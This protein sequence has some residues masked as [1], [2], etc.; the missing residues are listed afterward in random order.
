M[1]LVAWEMKKLMKNPVWMGLMLLFLAIDVGMVVGSPDWLLQGERPAFTPSELQADAV[2]LTNEYEELDTASYGDNAVRIMNGGGRE[3]EL[4]SALMR[5]KYAQLTP[6]VEQMART[7][8]GLEVTVSE[9]HY[10]LHHL[11]YGTLLKTVL[12]QAMLLAALLSAQSIDFETSAHT[13]GMVYATRRGR[14]LIVDKCG[15]SA[16]VALVGYL[17]L[18]AAV[19]VAFACVYPV[20]PV[21]GSSVSSLLHRVDF[22]VYGWQPFMTW[23]RFSEITYLPAVVLVGAGLVLICVFLAICL[24]TFLPNSYVAL[25][26]F[27]LL[28][29]LPMLVS[30]WGRGFAVQLASLTPVMVWQMIRHWFTDGY[31]LAFIPWFE[32]I[33]TLFYLMLSGAAAAFGVHRFKGV[34]LCD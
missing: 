15:A 34:N 24:S 11:L 14:R 2:G 20:R 33:S 13:T 1:R 3:E 21:L 27:A 32:S 12:I 5:W 30:V 23:I 19:A 10:P 6:R 29:A 16:A 25:G 22:G 31:Y 8:E 28:F 17:I 26:A 4:P 7:G 18:A 9:L